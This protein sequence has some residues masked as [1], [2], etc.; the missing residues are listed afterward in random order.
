M[1]FLCKH[2]IQKKNLCIHPLKINQYGRFQVI[3][4]S[5]YLAYVECFLESR[6]RSIPGEVL[7]AVSDSAAGVSGHRSRHQTPQTPSA[8]TTNCN[9]HVSIYELSSI[10]P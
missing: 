2:W 9:Q 1:L 4:T 10:H 8:K 7:H 3:N 6:H 5:I